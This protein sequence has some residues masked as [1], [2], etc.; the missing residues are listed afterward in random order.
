MRAALTLQRTESR[1][2]AE[3]WL[4]VVARL[5]DQLNRF[6]LLF[7]EA[8]IGYFT[9]DDKGAIREI[10]T[11]AAAL[12]GVDRDRILGKPFL[13]CVLR[14]DV[15]LFL[16]HLLR[17]SRAEA[18]STVA[19]ELRLRTVG[20]PTLEVRLSSRR[21]LLPRRP[22]VAFYTLVVDISEEQRREVALRSSEKLHREIVETANEGI[23]IV[24]EQNQIVFANRRMAVMVGTDAEDLLGRSGYDLAP[25]REVPQAQTAFE[26]RDIGSGGQTEQLLLRKD[27]STTPTSVSTALMHDARARFSGMIRM[28]TDATARA[29]LGRVRETLVRQLVAAQERER[30]RIARELHDQLGQHVVALSLGLARLAR[31]TADPQASPAISQL[32][33]VAESIG[34]DVHRLAIELRPSALDHLGLGVALASYAEEVSKRSGLEIDCHCGSLDGAELSQELQTGLYR[35][36]QE[37]LT[38][39]VKHAGAQHVSVILERR[40][41]DIQLIVEDDGIGLPSASNRFSGLGVAGMYERASLLGGTVTV[42]SSDGRG[43]TVFARIPYSTRD[44]DEHQQNTSSAAR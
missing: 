23:C 17:C 31:L 44:S 43:V 36:A 14:A 13:P 34:K 6:V 1:R 5:E 21:A 24:N 38:N 9:F 4:D 25:A 20:N 37:A 26:R 3:E 28:Y 32:Q 33:H 40:S 30:E 10:N 15:K 35:I 29:S 41:D 22:G 18:G 16:R 19:S 12:V 7:E 2:A 42:E 39:V 11:A 27:G 8:P